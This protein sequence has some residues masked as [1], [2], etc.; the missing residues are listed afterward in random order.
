MAAPNSSPPSA[1]NTTRT[2]GSPEA[3]VNQATTTSA[4]AAAMAGPLVGQALIRQPSAWSGRAG[5]QIARTFRATEMS[6]RSSASGAGCRS[7]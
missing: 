5:C 3:K 2:S 7:R 4:P 1:E 6:R